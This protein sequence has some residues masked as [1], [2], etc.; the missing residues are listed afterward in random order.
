MKIVLI[1]SGNVAT[2]LG[3]AFQ[4]CGHEIVQGYSRLDTN[5]KG[6]GKVLKCEHTN[7]INKINK[8]ADVYFIALKD[9][10]I[11]G[12]VNKIKFPGKVIIHTSA[13]L[14][15]NILNKSSKDFGVF[16]PLQSFTKD[17]V[18]DLK[19]ITIFIE[20]NNIR[21]K[22]VLLELAKCISDKVSEITFEQRLT[23]HVAAV[24]ANNFTNHLYK[25]AGDILKT[26][27][28]SFDV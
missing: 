22:K 9:D 1:G 7:D 11:E 5:A 28:L 26:S 2:H 24:F 19:E 13:S 27:G 8:K 4:N 25:I 20:S 15:M 21:S 3:K 18:I 17:R 23:L 12:F 16:Y 14:P 6:L 10:V